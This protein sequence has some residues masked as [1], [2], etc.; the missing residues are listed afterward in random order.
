MNGSDRFE[1]AEG[2][3]EY[4]LVITACEVAIR[5]PLER[6][7]HTFA[8]RVPWSLITELRERLDALGVDWRRAKE[9][10]E[11]RQARR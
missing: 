11:E 1:F 6:H 5:P 3:P 2:T 8:A 9:I 10:N 4:D 7:P